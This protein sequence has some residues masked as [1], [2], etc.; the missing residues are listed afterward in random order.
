MNI[1]SSFEQQANELWSGGKGPS[2]VVIAGGWSLSVGTRAIYPILLPYFRSEFDLTLTV[3]GL[4]VTVLWVMYALGQFPGGILADRQS[5]RTLMMISAIA[6]AVALVFVITASAPIV[7][8]AATG[9]FGLSQSLYPIA[10]LTTL[11]DIYPDRIGSALGMTMAAGDLGQTV[12]PPI[13]GALAAAIAWQAG[14]WFLIPLF[15]LAGISIWRTIAVRDSTESAADTLSIESTRY[16]VAEL[17]Q[18]NIVFIIFILF[19]YI[20]VWQSF[21]GLYPTYLVEQKGLSSSIAGVLFGLFFAVGI[22]VKPVAGAAYNRFGVRSSLLVVLVGPVAGFALLPVVNE[23]WQLAVITALVSSMLGSGAV[24]QSFLIDSFADDMRGTGLG[25]IRASATT[26]GAMGPVVFGL[27]ADQGY[28]DVGYVLLAM[29]LV[30]AI[31]LTLRVSHPS[32]H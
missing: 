5:E 25:V 17:R 2:L 19:L 30:G 9:V 28:F 29:I 22:V 32:D 16:I 4:L 27:I 31:V 8:F 13:V 20:F 15:L 10:R 21:T 18:P 24:T 14:F 3:A 26:L 23:F 11:S 12:L 6:G 7:L 1:L